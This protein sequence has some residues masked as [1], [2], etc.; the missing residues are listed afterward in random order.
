MSRGLRRILFILGGA[1]GLLLLA[2]LI[3]PLLVN[4]DPYK[5]GL[6]AAASDAMGMDVRV[7]GK[8]GIGFF[9]TFHL[10]LNGGRVLGEQ[11]ATVASARTATLFIELF[12]LL[13][14]EFRLH[15]IDLRQPMLFVERDSAGR[16]NI[17]RL[18]KATTLLRSMDGGS[19]ALTNGAVSYSDKRSGE[20]IEATGIDLTVRRIRFAGG[21][22][23]PPLKAISL[24]ANLTCAEIRT[25]TLAGSDL[26]MVVEA[27]DGIF[28]VNPVTMSL[29]G[30]RGEGSLRADV[31]GP[32]P[33][34]QVRCSLPDFRIEEFLKALSP[35]KAAEG[36]MSF[37]LNL[38]M[39]GGSWGQLIQTAAGDASLR[40]RD[41]TLMNND[42]DGAISRFDSSQNFN[43][44]DVGAVFLAGPVGL[45]VTK[46]YNFAGL[47]QGTGG[48]TRIGIVVSDWKVEHGVAR[49]KDVAM[50][51][52]K[53]RL[54]VQGGLDFVHG[55]FADMTVAVVDADGC[56]RLRQTIRGPFEKPEVEKPHVLASLA[57]PLTSLFKKAKKIFPAAPCEVFYSG[58]VA[59]PNQES[60]AH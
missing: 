46:G 4:L 56:P 28:E 12:P 33:L 21:T 42:L 6:E 25:K 22:S 51:T 13:H 53:N 60:A 19:V 7:A 10:T 5:P 11:G 16:F 54:A 50:A 48:T 27:S 31:T 57:G 1:A 43:L 9:P 52:P 45:A 32:V 3:A 36:E 14:K 38:S 41:L 59:P 58:S 18:K 24:G 39:Q 30:G 44:V 37:S 26:K 47:F 40:G 35:A 17:E 34:C 15:R 23:P 20:K 49:A 2:G 29:F 55:Q 8:I